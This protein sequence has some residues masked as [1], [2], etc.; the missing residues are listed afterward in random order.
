MHNKIKFEI[1][2]F[3]VEVIH[4]KYLPMSISLLPVIKY[5]TNLHMRF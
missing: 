5:V 1:I 3:I 2:I 4:W